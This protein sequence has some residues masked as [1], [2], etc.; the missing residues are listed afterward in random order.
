MFSL[1]ALAIAGTI[2]RQV[3]NALALTHIHDFTWFWAAAELCTVSELSLGIIFASV[4]ALQP[5]LARYL[6]TISHLRDNYYSKRDGVHKLD[7]KNSGAQ[8][9]VTIGKIRNTPKLRPEDSILCETVIVDKDEGDGGRG[10]DGG[11]ERRM[12]PPPDSNG[13]KRK[14]KIRVR[15]EQGYR[16]DY[17]DR[18]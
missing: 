16:V 18:E 9:L 8:E 13:E 6:A 12:I 15:V 3:T 17:S 10:D 7:D 4:P 2:A 14:S 1:G 5:L 11:S